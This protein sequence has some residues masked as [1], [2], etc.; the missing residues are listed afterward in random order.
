M[1]REGRRFERQVHQLSGGGVAGVAGG[2]KVECA[3][4]TT[5]S[6][7]TRQ[8]RFEDTESRERGYAG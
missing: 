6:A 1:R 8:L 5:S 4:K 3:D 2:N 7:E